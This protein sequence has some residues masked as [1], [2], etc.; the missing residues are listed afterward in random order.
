[1]ATNS[2]WC[3]F[4]SAGEI[5]LKYNEVLPRQVWLKLTT[6]NPFQAQR[7]GAEGMNLVKMIQAGLL[8][9]SKNGAASRSKAL[10][11]SPANNNKLQPSLCS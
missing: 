7:F 3:R 9:R 5:H 1:M 10:S 11:T 6:S 4:E 8:S 2:N